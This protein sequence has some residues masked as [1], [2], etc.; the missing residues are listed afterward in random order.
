MIMDLDANRDIQPDERGFFVVIFFNELNPEKNLTRSDIKYIF[1]KFG[2][3]SEI[4]YAEHG[5]NFISYK[6]KEGA[7]KAIEIVN[8]GKK[9]RVEAADW[10]PVKK[11]GY[12]LIILVST[13]ILELSTFVFECGIE[14]SRIVKAA[15]YYAYILIIKITLRIFA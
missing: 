10:Q 8:M 7:L 3:V 1:S 9:Y 13:F 4:K 5:R 6:E 14:F 11:N 12:K 2:P 15:K